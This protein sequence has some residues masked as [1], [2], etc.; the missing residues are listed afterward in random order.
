MANSFSR[1]YR[2]LIDAAERSAMDHPQQPLHGGAT[3]MHNPHDVVTM[4]LLGLAAMVEVVLHQAM[5]ALSALALLSGI[6]FGGFNAYIAWRN[7]EA[8]LARFKTQCF[9]EWEA[10]RDKAV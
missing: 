10:E 5:T 2:T 6:V 3:A 7:S 4:G 9:R 1:F 8:R